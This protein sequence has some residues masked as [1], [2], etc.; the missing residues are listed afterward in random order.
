MPVEKDGQAML[1]DNPYQTWK[2][3]NPELPDQ[4][5]TGSTADFRYP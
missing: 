4:K 3:V 2:D 5:M 1:V